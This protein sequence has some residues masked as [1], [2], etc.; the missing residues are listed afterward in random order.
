M[1]DIDQ[2][3]E[4]LSDRRVTIRATAAV[5][6]GNS[7]DGRAVSALIGVLSDANYGVR[8]TAVKSLS[9]LL[10][11][12]KSPRKLR[13]LLRDRDELVRIETAEALARV[14]DQAALPSLW[15]AFRDPSPLVRSY[16]AA[17]IG[18]LG[19]GRDIAALE[20]EIGRERS[21]TARVGILGA[22]VNR[23]RKNAM[24]ELL[25]QLESRD[26]RVRCATANTLPDLATRGE[27]REAVLA[28]LRKAL[29][30]ESTVAARSS[31]LSSIRLIQG[32]SKRRSSRRATSS[33]GV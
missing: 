20:R 8:M 7:Q 2:L 30:K 4:A 22:L 13:R 3:I 26:Y 28:A 23:G 5:H 32:T 29:S 21:D 18:E 14:G 25:A 10:K 6:L 19:R 31:I 33:R 1:R 9:E 17:A 16:V 27:T 11:G 15:R 12:S 24:S